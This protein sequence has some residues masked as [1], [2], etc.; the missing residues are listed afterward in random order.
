MRGAIDSTRKPKI[1]RAEGF[2]SVERID[3]LLVTETHHTNASPPATPHSVLLCHTGSSSSRAGM[4]L[5]ARK[6]RGWSCLK[7]FVLK[8]GYAMLSLL[9]CKKSVETLWIL[10]IY[11]DISGNNSLVHFYS[12]VRN[13]LADFVSS[14]DRIASSTPGAPPMWRGCV[15]LGD[16]NTVTLA[17]DRYPPKAPHPGVLK[18]MNDILA[19]CMARDVA[20]PDPFLK[21]YTWSMVRLGRNLLSRLD[22][23]YLP[24]ET[25][26]ADMPVS[27]PTNWSDHK[28]LYADC[29]ILRP[30]VE[31]ARPAR[32]LPKIDHL[33]SCPSFWTDVI[34]E[35]MVFASG[36]ITL[37]RWTAFKVKVLSLGIT[38]AKTWRKSFD[39][40]WLSALRGDMVAEEDLPQAVR[41][42]VRTQWPSRS[43][44]VP[45]Q[46][47]ARWRSALDDKDMPRHVKSSFTPKNTRWPLA[48]DPQQAPWTYPVPVFN[49]FLDGHHLPGGSWLPWADVLV[50]APYAELADFL[51]SRVVKKREAT[52][53]KFRNA[54]ARHTSAWFGSSSNKE[55]D[56]RGSRA[57]ISVEGLRR[58]PGDPAA[59]S[60]EGMLPIAHEFF[61]TLHTPEPMTGRRRFLQEKLLEE[62]SAEYSDKVKTS[63]PSGPFSLKEVLSLPSKMHNTAPGPDGIHN[64]FWKAL[65][66]RIDK[67]DGTIPCFWDTFRTL[68]DDIR[69]RGTSRCGLKDANLS[70]FFK[71]GD[72][73]LVAN[74]RPISS[75]NTDCKMYTNL[76]NS[77]LS[78][79]AV[80]L[81]HPDQKGFVPGRYITEHTRLAAEV[82]HLSNV[83]N[84]NGYIVSLDQVKA[85]DRVDLPWLLSVLKAMKVQE[86]LISMISDIVYKCKTR[87]RINGAY[88]RK[89]SLRRG[90]RQGDP[91]SCLLYDFAIEPMGMALRR[92]IKGITTMGLPVAK[93]LHFADDMNLF[94]SD[95]ED[96]DALGRTLR[97][98]SLAIGSKFNYDKT[99]IL[100]VGS[101]YHRSIDVASS[102]YDP[103]LQCFEGAYILEAGCPLRVLGVWVGSE[104]YASARWSQISSHITK[105]IRQWNAIGASI[106]NRVLLAKALMLSRCY[107]LL[108]G[109][110]IPPRVLHLISQKIMRFV[111]GKFNNTRYEAMCA[112]IE[113]GGLDCPSLALRRLAYDAKFFSDLITRPT[114]TKWKQWTM[115]DLSQASSH[116][117][118]RR[119]SYGVPLNPLVQHAHVCMKLVE[120]RVRQGLKSLRA[121]RYDLSRCFPSRDARH[122]MP[123]LYHPAIRTTLSKAPSILGDLGFMKVGH[124]VQPKYK[125]SRAPKDKR[126][127]IKKKVDAILHELNPTQWSDSAVFWSSCQKLG[128]NVKIWPKMK[129]ALG[130][131][132]ILGKGPSLLVPRSGIS[133][134]RAPALSVPLRWLLK[135]YPPSGHRAVRRGLFRLPVCNPR[136]K[137]TPL[138][139]RL[140]GQPEVSV[141]TDGS[142]LYN[143][144]DR[145]IAGAAWCTED[146]ILAFA[147]ITGIIPSNNVAE[148]VA[149]ILALKAW[150]SHFLT[151]HT[152]SKYVL[153]L[154]DGGLL[155]MERDGWPD[156]P[157]FNYERPFSLSVLLK[158]FLY[159][160]RRHNS[161]LKFV[162]VKGH[163]RDAMNDMADSL[164]KTGVERDTYEFDVASLHTPK[165]WV[166]TAPVL[167]CQSLAHITYCIVRDMVPPPILGRKFA[168]F[169]EDWTSYMSLVFHVDLDI[170]SSFKNLWT[171]NVPIG[172]KGLLWK[173]A[174]GSIPI[175]E[176]WHGAS[177][178]GAYCACGE[179]LSLPHIWEGCE[180]YRLAPL[181]DALDG[182]LLTL[183]GGFSKTV[184]FSA[185]PS[186][187]WYPLLCL[188]KIEKSLDISRKQRKSLKNN[189]RFREWAI[190]MYLWTIWRKRMKE[191][192]VPDY[193]FIPEFHVDDMLADIKAG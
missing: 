84:T 4:A 185:W 12:D 133:S 24:Y 188:A 10:C 150:H 131:A 51:D 90:V 15:A 147:R 59:L 35:W 29:V 143:G 124:L 30:R 96:L 25:W 187:Y 63:S 19:I 26:E 22:R 50:P 169:C 136:P 137:W 107:Y 179:T 8:E 1:H 109:N 166:D 87:V 101:L 77:R 42:A 141:W 54:E 57:S 193:K 14:Y 135:L 13:S 139:K 183:G 74:Y 186:P 97:D 34:A 79:W 43:P 78:P 168:P 156:T 82:A 127:M 49:S 113:E 91:L 164:A 122:D 174:S 175:G 158:H 93:L 117:R 145:C 40:D 104:D 71:K 120:P 108:D 28:L 21:G 105:I 69:S 149:V 140:G 146:G 65:A 80:S 9:H 191:I 151:V 115:M 138:A 173:S 106:R 121:L 162:W 167:N 123:A 16:W 3:L 85:Y 81:L 95:R 60:L 92:V 160:L 132:N 75:M 110:G 119:R 83:T 38:E 33:N 163:S 148:V 126:K 190:G 56:E 88:S 98:A 159:T 177:D 39:R 68:T 27:I 111:R 61:T 70:L 125:L 165:S 102:T 73:T 44:P 23:L 154:V 76:V 192:M 66:A 172:L 144:E 67:A 178:L 58:S 180:C 32:R 114:D 17:A 152:D 45:R 20:G 184:D 7:T 181:K 52:L 64:G 37:E 55:A 142:A 129:G 116:L 155:A 31:I 182:Y 128:K 100:R 62:V 161:G 157:F 72:P 112:P 41:D 99:D 134:F 89:Y 86:D 171:M 6:D 153:G 2:L 36:P 46:K 5:L 48:T 18:D 176:L 118:D 103:L 94:L 189:R 170:L 47:G 11:G 130:C 53:K